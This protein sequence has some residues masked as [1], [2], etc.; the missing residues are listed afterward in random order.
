[1]V[2]AF[3]DSDSSRALKKK[4]IKNILERIYRFRV[5]MHTKNPRKVNLNDRSK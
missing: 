1:M 4:K 5:V 2:P 3:T